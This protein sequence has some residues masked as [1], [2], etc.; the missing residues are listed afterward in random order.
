MC[1]LCIIQHRPEYFPF[2][3]FNITQIALGHPACIYILCPLY[4]KFTIKDK[5]CVSHFSDTVTEKAFAE[6]RYIYLFLTKL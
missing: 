1:L 6:M 4:A 2:I 5:I 3:V